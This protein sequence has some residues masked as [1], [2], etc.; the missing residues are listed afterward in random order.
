MIGTN[1]VSSMQSGLFYGYLGM[2]DGILERLLEE[3][4]KDVKVIATGGLASLISE[5]SRYIKQVDEQLTL[6]GLRIIWER[7]AQERARDKSAKANKTKGGLPAASAA[8]A[9]IRTRGFR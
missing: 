1:T 8:K 4:G 5:S 9:A 6:E 7:N 2:V 3:M